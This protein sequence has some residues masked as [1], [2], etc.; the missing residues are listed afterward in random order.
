MSNREH[1]RDSC[2]RKA[3]ES[4]RLVESFFASEA[5]NVAACAEAMA[6]RLSKGARLFVM[7]N[8]GSLCDAQHIAVE[9]QHPIIEKRAAFPAVAL[10]SDVA[11]ASAVGND[12]DYAQ[13]LRR[14]LELLA[15]P[16]DVVI[17]ISTSGTSANVNR[18]LRYA[19]ERDLLTI[20]F[21]GRDGGTLV[22]HCTYSFVVPSWSIHRIQECHTTLLHVLWDL[23]HVALGE[24]DVI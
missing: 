1:M 21:T 15:S 14:Q 23:V 10:G 22:D 18:A 11:F 12:A 8:G 9:F 20:G 5:E 17:G 24:D 3:Q 16:G 13:V 4:A 6:T 2:V 19:R 7:G